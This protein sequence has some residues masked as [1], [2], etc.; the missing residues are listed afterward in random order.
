MDLLHLE[1][2]N[3]LIGNEEFSSGVYGLYGGEN[4]NKTFGW[5][6]NCKC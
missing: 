3:N 2:L 4:T 6:M 1:N 5:E